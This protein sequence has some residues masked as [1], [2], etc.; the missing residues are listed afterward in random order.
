MTRTDDD[1][2]DLK[3]GVGT[4]AAA[5]VAMRAL[6]SKRPKPLIDDPLAQPLVE[7][8]GVDHYLRMANGD[9]TD[10][11]FDLALMADGMAVR[12]VFFDG[13][14][15]AAMATGVRQAVILACGLD[16]R[17]HRLAWPAGT[18]VFEVDQPGV[19]DAKVRA[20]AQ[21]GATPNAEL[22]SVGIDLRQDW[23]AALRA[24]GF[25]A[26]L[27]TAWIAE[28][29][30]GYLP[31]EA[32]DRLF[33][34]ITGLS[35]PGSHLAADWLPDSAAMTSDRARAVYAAERQRSDG[36]IQDPGELIYHGKRNDVDAY[37]K[38]LGWRASTQSAEQRFA[39]SDVQFRRDD[40]LIGIFNARYTSA[41]LG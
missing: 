36:A 38:G 31:P 12:T 16:T 10:S 6:A 24:Q 17:P 21:V 39:Q 20:M 18:T 5:I 25:D 29:L 32:Q 1:S 22:H 30:M 28:G 14:F 8:L 37:L 3:T 40:F 7:A 35:A 33:D 4:T 11:G 23:P 26:D 19:I 27:P 13:F 15:A 2:W 41:T 9:A 34:T